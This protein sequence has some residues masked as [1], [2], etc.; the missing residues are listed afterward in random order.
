MC[1]STPSVPKT[2]TPQEAQQPDLAALLRGRN[3]GGMQGG[4][5][6]TSPSGVTRGALTTGTPTLLGS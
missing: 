4:S 2:K 3:R 1:L 6:L 5:I